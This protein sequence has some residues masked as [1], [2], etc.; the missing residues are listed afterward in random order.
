MSMSSGRFII[1]RVPPNSITDIGTTLFLIRHS[2]LG[3][4]PD[5]N[6]AAII[7]NAIEISVDLDCKMINPM[8]VPVMIQIIAYLYLIFNFFISNSDGLIPSKIT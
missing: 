4:S 6:M 7:K 8:E 2:G 3:C 1:N 5:M